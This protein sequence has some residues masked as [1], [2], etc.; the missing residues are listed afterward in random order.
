MSGGTAVSGNW[1]ATCRGMTALGRIR[2]GASAEQDFCAVAPATHEAPGVVG[3]C[4]S[5][6]PREAVLD[7][8]DAALVNVALGAALHQRYLCRKGNA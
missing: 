5:I 3:L 8:Q 7:C 6:R 2:Q 4:M 1:L